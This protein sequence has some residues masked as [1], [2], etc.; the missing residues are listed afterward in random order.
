M[1]SLLLTLNRLPFR[2]ILGLKI[3]GCQTGISRTMRCSYPRHI[4]NIESVC[5]KRNVHTFMYIRNICFRWNK[6]DKGLAQF[7]AEIMMGQFHHLRTE[8]S[9]LNLVDRNLESKDAKY[10]PCLFRFVDRNLESKDAKYNPCL[11]WFVD[12]NLE[13]KDAKYNPCL[14]RFVGSKPWIERC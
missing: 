5:I 4:T 8:K 10:N 13:S 11:F 14:F 2:I 6:Y 9:F 7:E 3:L 12:R 1:L